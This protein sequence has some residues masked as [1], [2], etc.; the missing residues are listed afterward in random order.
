MAEPETQCTRTQRSCTSA[1]AC[2]VSQQRRGTGKGVA[3]MCTSENRGLTARGCLVT[4]PYAC[5]RRECDSGSPGLERGPGACMRR[6]GANAVAGGG[7]R[8]CSAG[9]STRTAPVASAAALRSKPLPGREGS[10][11]AAC[12]TSSK[13]TQAATQGQYKVDHRAQN[14]YSYLRD[15]S[16]AAH[17][18]MCQLPRLALTA[19]SGGRWPDGLPTL[20]C[21]PGGSGSGGDHRGSSRAARRRYA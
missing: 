11:E 6:E 14:Q 5:G 4:L 17:G 18:A 10:V 13:Y 16:A 19:A 21:L 1:R 12:H 3:T 7:G 9:M 2:R 15:Q 20:P 8:G